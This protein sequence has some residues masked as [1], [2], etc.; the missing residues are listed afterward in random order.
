[1]TLLS[2]LRVI[3]VALL[4]PDSL[5]MHLAD[6]GAD[7]IKVEEPPTG[8]YVRSVGFMRVDG[9]SAMHRR[10]NRGKRSI[11]L[12]LRVDEGRKA[13]EDL[14]AVS[15]IVVEGLRPGALERRGLGYDR[16]RAVNPGIVMVSLS[17]FGQDGPY[18][19]LASHGVA[20]DAYAGLAPPME[21][22][23]GFP[24][25]PRHTAVGI[26]AAA[27]FGAFGAVSAVLSARRT[28]TG[29]HLDIAQADA[30]TWWNGP[31][32]ERD[33]WWER[34]GKPGAEPPGSG[35]LEESVRYQY[36]ETADGKHVLFM[37][38]EAK[39]W[40]QFCDAV[41]R[42]D[43]Y[44]SHPPKTPSDHDTGNRQLRREL[45]ALFATRSQREWIELFLI[46]DVPGAP[47][48]SGSDIRADPHFQWRAHWLDESRHGMPLLG[49]PLR[50][51]S[52]EALQEPSVAPQVGEHTEE[53][54]RDLLG[55]SFN[56][57]ADVTG[58]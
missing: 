5:A 54:L 36:Y 55:Y 50:V 20:Y 22:A 46:A 10:W 44:E 6:L 53:V 35:G 42:P 37:A 12:N 2:D 58:A 49:S 11:A 33:A 41:G 21:T 38:T 3:E 19:D 7:V 56:R 57:I 34:A 9:I 32:I 23:D 18:R 31:L 16:L 13:F 39:F 52:G 4:A 15:D 43:L 40:K 30:A 29:C 17:G 14:V 45:V 48:Y 24:T 25:V 8:D 1:M 51:A 47:A 28:G 26:H 27:L